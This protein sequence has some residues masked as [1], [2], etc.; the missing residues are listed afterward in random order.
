MCCIPRKSCSDYLK[1]SIAHDRSVQAVLDTDLMVAARFGCNGVA[2]FLVRG[3]A[4]NSLTSLCCRLKG[5]SA[6]SGD[7]G[8]M[9][10]SCHREIHHNFQTFLKEM[11]CTVK[12]SLRYR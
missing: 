4:P 6:R 7:R 8:R 1:P 2:L 11:A 9:N 10:S 12:P 5:L 3:I